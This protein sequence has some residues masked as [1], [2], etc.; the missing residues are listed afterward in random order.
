MRCPYCHNSGLREEKSLIH[1]DEALEIIRKSRRWIDGV[2]ITGGEPLLKE[3]IKILL[4]VLK[5]SGF[6]IKLDTNGFNPGLLKDILNCALADYI[7]LDLKASIKSEKR[8]AEVCGVGSAA[9]KAAQALDILKESGSDFEVRT[10]LIPGIC[11]Y[12]DVM[13]NLGVVGKETVYALGQFTP[14]KAASR[15]LRGI[16]PYF[17]GEIRD[18]AK[19]AVEKGYKVKARV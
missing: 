17:E 1:Q 19:S 9:A 10:V 16:K 15:K 6:L 18:F 2:V 11:E 12:R 8:Y 3:D 14:D 13:E 5:D 7:A 4:K